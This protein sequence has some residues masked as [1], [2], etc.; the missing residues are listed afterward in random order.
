MKLKLTTKNEIKKEKMKTK[1]ENFKKAETQI[2]KK[3]EINNQKIS[4]KLT[5]KKMKTKLDK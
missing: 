4:R 1:E 3:K 5:N 2:T